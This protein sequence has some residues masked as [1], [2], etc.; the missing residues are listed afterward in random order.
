[1]SKQT[2]HFERRKPVLEAYLLGLVEY[3]ACLALQH[4]LVYE[5][6]GCTDGQIALL[7]CEHPPLVTIGR[8]GSRLH[9]R[10]DQR[11]LASQRL[12]VRWVNRGG[13]CLVHAPGQLAIYPIVPLGWHGWKVGEFL[14][15]L[16]AGLSRV[17]ERLHIMPT[18]RPA[19]HGLWGRSGQL[20]AFGAAVKSWTTYHG[21]FVNVDT[22]P[23]LLRLV[24]SDPLE[25]TAMSS[26]AIERQQAVKMSHVRSLIVPHLAAAFG[27]EQ[28]HVYSRHPLF[29]SASNR[30]NPSRRVG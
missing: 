13:G 21:A 20:V 11:E 23:R 2:I 18:T 10:A 16:Q 8:Q 22:S 3:E 1:M 25:R 19:A 12:A 28:Y 26:L 4:R 14:D 27:C 15:R 6:G 17:L 9:L 24:E 7:L 5:A 30:V 29:L